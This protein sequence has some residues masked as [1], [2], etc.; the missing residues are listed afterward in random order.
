[1]DPM[2]LSFFN[3]KVLLDSR[4]HDVVIDFVRW[5]VFFLSNRGGLFLNY[6]P[7]GPR[8]PSPLD[9][10]KI[11]TRVSSTR[12]PPRKTKAGH[13]GEKNGRKSYPLS[14]ETRPSPGADCKKMPETVG[15]EHGRG[16]P[17]RW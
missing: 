6:G 2:V 10:G 5:V 16:V 13:R 1:M 14:S 15:S 17:L 7:I 3:P 4:F 11:S 8:S 12:S 9:K